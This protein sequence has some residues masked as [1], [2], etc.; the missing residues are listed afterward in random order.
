MKLYQK[1]THPNMSIDPGPVTQADVDAFK[2]GIEPLAAA[3]KLGPLL[4]QFPPAS[5]GRQK[6]STIWRGC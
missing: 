1:F 2:G 6:R 3:G 4:A 5:S